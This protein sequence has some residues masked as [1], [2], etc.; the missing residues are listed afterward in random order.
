MKRLIFA[1]LII[2]AIGGGTAAYYMRRGGGEPQVNTAPATRGEIVDAVGSTGTLQ[3]VTSVT[4]GS[5][6]SGNI[7]ELHAD[8][9]SM[10]K[11]GQVIARIDPTLLQAQLDQSR[12]NLEK[13]KADRDR[14]KVSL[15]DAQIKLKRAEDL[16]EKKLIT[17]ADLDTAR[18]NVKTA[19]ASL[20]SSDKTVTQAEATVQQN[21]VNVEHCVITA[22]IDGIVTQRS[23]DVGQTVAA[24]MSAPTIFVIAADLTKM[25]VNAS[26]DESDVGRI[27]PGQQVTFRVDAYPGREF[28]G[29]VAQI[30]LQ[31]TV[32]QNVT[33]YSTIISVPNPDYSLKIGMT[34][35]LK[36]QIDIREDALRIPNATLRF[37]PT[38]EMFAAFQQE[39]PPEA[40]GARGGRG[41]PGGQGRP[42]NAGSQGSQ[43]APSAQGAQGQSSQGAPGSAGAT[44]RGEQPNAEENAGRATGGGRGNGG[45]GRGQTASADQ[46]G[47]GRDNGNTGGGRGNGGNGNFGGGG[48]GNGGGR[49]NADGQNA[50]N[51]QG[52]GGGRG[53]R[54]GPMPLD[55]FKTLPADQ[56]Q[57]M[58]ERMKGR[59]VDTKPY[60]DAM[61]A[62]GGNKMAVPAPKYGEAMSAETIDAL[63]PPL[64]R[65][66]NRGRVWQFVDGKL[67][68]LNVR[69][70][71]TDGNQT[72]VLE[73]SGLEPGAEL[74]TG[75][76]LPNQNRTTGVGQGNPFQQGGRGPGGPG[77][78]GGRGRG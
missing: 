27:R 36:I 1:F 67:K 31:P 22:P 24:S 5:Q 29:V 59:G 10:V 18:I 39:V 3:A 2:A 11:K 33:T 55:Q 58:V 76:V 4:V 66:E 77:G 41:G 12:A 70:G 14:N 38:N 68:V 50:G 71:I 20:V 19:E 25:Q 47:G 75:I 34:A 64:P 9:N 53:G 56:Q 48:R 62:G 28:R 78:P 13:S 46:T 26:I 60:E 65:I 61:K 7:S 54:G 74:V 45:S 43:S 72:E 51:F 44:P 63:F 37:R 23:V 21:Q 57:Q 52:G 6:V 32:V 49:R 40:G 42:Q 35:N 15:E 8:F 69:T 16:N 73:G 30:R 17:Q